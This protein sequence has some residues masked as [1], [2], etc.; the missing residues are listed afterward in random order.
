MKKHEMLAMRLMLFLMLLLFS[1]AF[2]ESDELYGGMV[3]GWTDGFPFERYVWDGVLRVPIEEESWQAWDFYLKNCKI[4]EVYRIELS[5]ENAYGHPFV[6]TDAVTANEAT[7]Y[8]MVPAD[9]KPGA[10]GPFD[11]KITG[12]GTTLE[13]QVVFI[14][15]G[16][17]IPDTYYYENLSSSGIMPHAFMTRTSN[18]EILI[19]EPRN[20]AV[21]F[22]DEN[23]RIKCKTNLT[24]HPQITIKLRNAKTDELVCSQTL[25]DSTDYGVYG[26]SFDFMITGDIQD[27]EEYELIIQAGGREG[28]SRFT[29]VKTAIED[30]C[31]KPWVAENHGDLSVNLEGVDLFSLA[32]GDT[33][34]LEG[35]INNLDITMKGGNDGVLYKLSV[36]G[37]SASAKAFEYGLLYTNESTTIR[38][39]QR[40]AHHAGIYGPF[41][42]KLLGN[43]QVFTRSLYFDVSGNFTPTEVSLVDD[44]PE[45]KATLLETAKQTCFLYPQAGRTYSGYTN[46]LLQCQLYNTEPDASDIKFELVDLVNGKNMEIR[47]EPTPYERQ[48]EYLYYDIIVNDSIASGHAYRLTAKIDNS[49]ASVDIVLVDENKNQWEKNLPMDCTVYSDQAILDY[50]DQFLMSLTETPTDGFM[51]RKTFKYLADDPADS[52]LRNFAIHNPYVDWERIVSAMDAMNDAADNALYEEYRFVL[53]EIENYGGEPGIDMPAMVQ[54][55]QENW[56]D[57]ASFDFAF[58]MGMRGGEAAYYWLPVYFAN[59]DGTIYEDQVYLFVMIVRPDSEEII[60]NGEVLAEIPYYTQD[61]LFI[62]DSEAIREVLTLLRAEN[63]VY[64]I[65]EEN[66]RYPALRNGDASDHVIRLQTALVKKGYQ[67]SSIDGVFGDATED[68]VKLYQEAMGL[69]VTGVADGQLLNML[70]NTDHEKTLLLNWL[71]QQ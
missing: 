45:I 51:S 58:G 29:L 9:E 10:T 65:R 1:T 39:T 63:D 69:E 32:D 4:G 55:L 64:A 57:L 41:E 24:R 59:A 43:G 50:F 37:K 42:V 21:Y 56:L 53:K 12:G 26:T 49:A 18:V 66:H 3:D 31:N 40:V 47:Y 2:A 30:E 54:F 20:G 67:T 11:L 17:V 13:Y 62:A 38:D 61:L 15:K 70:L 7:V 46:G 44:A 16:E 6:Y 48:G 28:V 22:G 60:V 27:G 68:A 25:E 23:F 8:F 19:E 71:I 35:S 33:V 14:K 52:L 34:V 36:T 5:G